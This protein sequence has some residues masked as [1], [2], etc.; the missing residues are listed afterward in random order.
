MILLRFMFQSK[1]TLYIV[2][3]NRIIRW[4]EIKDLN[5]DFRIH[6]TLPNMYSMQVAHILSENS[7]THTHFLLFILFDW[8]KLNKDMKSN[9]LLL[10]CE[11]FVCIQTSSKHKIG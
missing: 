4:K 8:C 11:C 1:A 7:C 5:I 2:K 10:L 9:R 6:Y 3:L